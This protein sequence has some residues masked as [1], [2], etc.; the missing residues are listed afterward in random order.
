M[1][2]S[3]RLSVIS[4]QGNQK[5][6]LLEVE[7]MRVR[8]E[9]KE[10]VGGVSLKIGK[11]EIVALMGPNGSGKSSLAKAL[12]GSREYEAG[13]EVWWYG[14]DLS[15]LS[16]PSLVK[17]SQTVLQTA[18]GSVPSEERVRLSHSFL[19][20]SKNDLLKLEMH[21][22]ARLGLFLAWQNPP[23][24]EGVK[25][26]NLV[27]E[28]LHARGMEVKSMVELKKRLQKTLARVGLSKEFW[29]REVNVGMSGGEK[30]RLLLALMLML[31]PKLVILDEI[32][33][34]LDVDSLKIA[35]EVVRE[36]REKGVGFLIITHYGRFLEYVE[37]D[38][39]V[40]MKEG[41]VMKEGGREIVGEIEARGFGK[42][43]V[44]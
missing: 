24:I 20:A 38:R 29:N 30:K 4:N 1:R 9:D 6:R 34:G 17:D 5:I 37:V 22:R 2:N 10:V 15:G 44:R 28:S 27:K 33:S 25:V 40:V 13:G 18:E 12:M 8:I 32:D 14:P 41:K 21:E 31:E 26:F 42:N 23:A 36:M 39:V 16:K 19:S 11:G 43:S 35:G 3:D 7:G